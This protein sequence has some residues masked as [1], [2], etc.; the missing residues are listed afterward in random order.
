MRKLTTTLLAALAITLTACDQHM[1]PYDVSTT[2][3]P[4]FA[5]GDAAEGVSVLSYNLYVGA[6]LDRVIGALASPDPADDFPELLA[7]IGTL[8]ATDLPARIE[9]I[10]E[11]IAE[12]RPA[13]VGLQEVWDVQ[14]DLRGYG[15][16]VTISQDFIARLQQALQERG[17]PYQ[18]AGSVRNTDASPIPGIRV[19]DHDVVL[20][21]PER[22]TVHTAQGRNFLANIGPVAP[23]LTILRGYVV[24]DAEVDG[25]P[26]MIVNAHLES[27]AGAALSGLRALQ[28]Q[29][30]VSVV[31][32]APLA[33]VMGDLNDTP[34][35]PMHGVLTGAGMVD[36][37]ATLR[38]G[39]EGGTCCHRPD[40]SNRN[41]ELTQ[42][43]DYLLTR[44]FDR[45]GR[46]LQG[47]IDLVGDR[48]SDRIAGSEGT[49]W[50]SDHAGIGA[51]LRLP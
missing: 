10:A 33:V 43:I 9:A 35:S 25:R 4:V 27:G 32:A 38:P 20:V 3:T 26:M 42:R 18:V 1:G 11:R 28:A 48:T 39:V 44:G 22:V 21:D 49:I 5:P 45:P 36:G 8:Q 50:P 17:L 30:L 6:D 14:I 34:G 16:P 13:V 40:L 51:V 12:R 37:W 15:V 23:G 31:G 29:E 7:G 19:V 41:P 24:L 47:R 46:P 2:D